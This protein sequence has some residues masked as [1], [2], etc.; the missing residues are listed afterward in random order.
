L[1]CRAPLRGA[2]FRCY[3]RL[4]RRASPAWLPHGQGR[5]ALNRTLAIALLSARLEQSY[6][7]YV[8][9]GH[10]E[11]VGDALISDQFSELL[12][13]LKPDGRLLVREHVD[14]G[15]PRCS[16]ASTVAMCP[17]RPPRTAPLAYLWSAVLFTAGSPCRCDCVS[18]A[19][20]ALCHRPAAT[21]MSSTDGRRSQDTLETVL[22]LAGFVH[23]IAVRGPC[24][25][26]P[27]WPSSAGIP[28][29]SAR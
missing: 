1:V 4:P 13:V 18:C 28:A 17:A 25:G 22:K 15:G 29:C 5:P 7:D 10:L 24:A 26:R 3:H 14:T 8:L 6:F 19:R 21:D 20:A 23:L 16:A 12:K 9:V 27:R 2:A 11:P